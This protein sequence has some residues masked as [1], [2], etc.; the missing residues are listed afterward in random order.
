MPTRKINFDTVRKIGL[1]W[2][3]VEESTAYG[4]PALKDRGKLLACVPTHRSAE[5]GSLAGRVGFDR[6]KL[7]AAAPDCYCVT[8]LSQLQRRA[9]SH[10]VRHARCPA[11]LARHGSQVRDRRLA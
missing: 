10:V 9:G 4:S 3:G 8:E 7:L 2:P 11:R 5:P 1:A 6:A